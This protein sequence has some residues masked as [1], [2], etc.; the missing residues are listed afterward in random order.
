MLLFMMTR[1]KLIH[2]KE[3]H[4]K[5]IMSSQLCPLGVLKE[6]ANTMFSPILPYRKRRAI[7]L[8]N[9]GAAMK[10][11]F[12]L[13]EK[14]LG[15]NDSDSLE[16]QNNMVPIWLD[17]LT[18]EGRNYSQG[19]NLFSDNI[20]KYWNRYIAFIS[21]D[22][23]DPQVWTAW[24]FG[25]SA[26][27]AET[28]SEKDLI[29]GLEECLRVAMHRIKNIDK[30]QLVARTRWISDPFTRGAYSSIPQT[31]DKELIWT[32]DLATPISRN[33]VPILLF[34]GEA[35]SDISIGTVNGAMKSA[36]KEVDRLLKLYK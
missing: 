17:G 3:V 10:L 11:I 26:K 4:I 24:L 7:E 18:Y 23:N 34:A 12:R 5:L 31:C 25:E 29:I 33:K 21:R 6:R 14:V 16:T 9:A 35:T 22:I 30:P 20:R 13:D 2:K 15:A 19:Y 32:G 27:F 28:L 1:L 36:R 8:M